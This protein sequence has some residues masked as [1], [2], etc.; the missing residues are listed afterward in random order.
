V[1]ADAVVIVADGSRPEGA[2]VRYSVGATV[3]LTAYLEDET[4][5]RYVVRDEAPRPP[6]A[7]VL[8]LDATYVTGDAAVPRRVLP[9]GRYTLVLVARDERGAAVERRVPV[10]V[11]QADTVPPGLRDVAA[12]PATISPYDPGYEGE[13]TVSFALDEA[14]EVAL[15][16]RW[17]SA[18]R[19]I[20]T[21]PA[22]REPGLHTLT[23]N[24]TIG[25]AQP[26]D[27]RYSLE[28]EARDRAGNVVVAQATVALIGTT[29]PDARITAVRF[30]PQRLLY[31]EPLR[32]EIAVRNVGA[33]TLRTQ[34]PPPGF[35]YRS[36]ETFASVEG[37]RFASRRNYWRVGIDWDAGPE[38]E[39]ERYP[40][41]W[42]LGRDLA[43]GE[44]T[45]VVGYVQLREPHRTLRVHAALI[46]EGT[47]YHVAR[48]GTQVVEIE[49]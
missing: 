11:T 10:R 25:N 8:P 15:A 31:G 24:G 45:T 17:P 5:R 34:G 7:Y 39:S 22:W 23:W 29:P 13:A 4:G 33:V 37:G 32:V 9:D 49:R 12:S 6:G 20:L 21:P 36:G 27:G 16:V 18:Q 47:T 40:F 43:P 35:T 3:W 26:P 42:G 2:G 19:T 1:P 30:T 14:A 41:R 48:V 44:E 38:A 46:R 28:V